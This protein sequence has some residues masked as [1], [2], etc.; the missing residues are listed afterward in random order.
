MMGHDTILGLLLAEAVAIDVNLKEVTGRTA[1]SWA[2]AFG[3]EGNAKLLLD[4]GT[5]IKSED[6]YGW[7]PLSRAAKNGHEATFKL[8]LDRSADFNSEDNEGQAP[9]SSAVEKHERMFYTSEAGLAEIGP[10]GVL[11]DYHMRL[12][13]LEQQNQRRATNAQHH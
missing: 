1:L 5:I 7:E 3:Q 9:L 4:R 11:A 8:L 12:V 2:A 6:K 13:L 10:R